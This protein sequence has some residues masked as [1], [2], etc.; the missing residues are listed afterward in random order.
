M[1]LYLKFQY[2]EQKTGRFSHVYRSGGR[3]VQSPKQLV[4]HFQRVPELWGLQF[5]NN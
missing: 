4:S 5:E 1:K 3:G 2:I